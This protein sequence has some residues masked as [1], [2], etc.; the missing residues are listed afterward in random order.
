MKKALT[1]AV[2]II[3]AVVLSFVLGTVPIAQ[4]DDDDDDDR[5]RKGITILEELIRTDGAQTLVAAVQV[6]DK[7]A[8]GNTSKSA[9]G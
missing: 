7:S 3:F 2:V 5:R 6:V 9:S 8:P 1:L 4:A